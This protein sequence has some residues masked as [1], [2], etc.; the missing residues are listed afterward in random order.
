M[1][2]CAAKLVPAEPYQP[3]ACSW[4]PNERGLLSS[5]FQL[6]LSTLYGIG[7]ARRGWVTRVKGL[8]GGV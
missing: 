3:T 6:N 1:V 4:Q 2:I 8:S 7:G 5:T